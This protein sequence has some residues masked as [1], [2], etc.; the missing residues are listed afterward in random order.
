MSVYK[1]MFNIYIYIY[2]YI[3]VLY[4]YIYMFNIYIHVYYIHA[5]IHT[6]SL[7][8]PDGAIR[9]PV[10]FRLMI[11]KS[12]IYFQFYNRVLKCGILNLFWIEIF[13]K[14]FR[15]R[16]ILNGE[17]RNNCYFKF[18]KWINTSSKYFVIIVALL[19][20]HHMGCG[21]IIWAVESP[22]GLWS[23]HMGCGVTIWAVES[24]YGLRSHHMGCGVHL[25]SACATRHSPVINRQQQEYKQQLGQVLCE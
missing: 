5:I 3:H 9:Q 21:V 4:I 6:T 16:K 2:M 17:N 8:Q 14:N 7:S 15:N 24:P 19:V 22:Y 13:Y 12:I 23:H 11:S 10:D 25:Y 1:S 18:Y 20:H